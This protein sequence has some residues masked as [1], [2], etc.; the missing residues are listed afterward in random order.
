MFYHILYMAK[1]FDKKEL[2]SRVKKTDLN[3]VKTAY[4]LDASIFERFKAECKKQKVAQ[5]RVIEEFMKVFLGDSD[6]KN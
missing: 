2:L 6:S 1:L 4:T 3:R 5:S